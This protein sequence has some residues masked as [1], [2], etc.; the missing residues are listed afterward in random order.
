ME[1]NKVF[2]NLALPN[3]SNYF[4]F[5]NNIMPFCTHTN[6]YR[7]THEHKGPASMQWGFK[8]IW[9]FETYMGVEPLKVGVIFKMPV[10]NGF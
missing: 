5:L 6:M 7:H 8:P 4:S 1:V 9:G 2:H 3:H 10:V